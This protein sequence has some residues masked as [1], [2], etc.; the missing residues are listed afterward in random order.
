[1]ATG[2]FLIWDATKFLNHEH[3]SSI[4]V[5]GTAGL[6]EDRKSA[7]FDFIFLWFLSFYQGEGNN[8]QG[9][10]EVL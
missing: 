4:L 10:S 6:G 9:L 3:I 1:M 5:C 7:A 8:I 2:R